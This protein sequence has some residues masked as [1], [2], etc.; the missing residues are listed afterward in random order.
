MSIVEYSCHKKHGG[1]RAPNQEPSLKL[2]YCWCLKE[3][4]SQPAAKDY[5]I[6]AC[7]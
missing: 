7:E 4:G 2:P 3:D 1:K 5:G 6:E